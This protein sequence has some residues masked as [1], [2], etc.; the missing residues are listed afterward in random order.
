MAVDNPERRAI[1]ALCDMIERYEQ[2]PQDRKLLCAREALREASEV[3][4]WGGVIPD[5]H[6]CIRAIELWEQGY[7]Q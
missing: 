3:A 1:S 4:N 7:G 5:V 6:N 2:P